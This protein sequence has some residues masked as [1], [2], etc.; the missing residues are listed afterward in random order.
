MKDS[1]HNL[2]LRRHASNVLLSLQPYPTVIRSLGKDFCKI[3]NKHLSD[4]EPK[5]KPLSKKAA[6]PRVK[7][8]KKKN[9][10]DAN[11]DLLKKKNRKM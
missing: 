1:N 11:E 4:E 8:S 3:Q 10:K 7:Q 6:A 9:L 2:A 5:K